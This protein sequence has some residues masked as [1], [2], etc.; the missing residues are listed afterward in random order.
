M[1][2]KLDYKQMAADIVGLVGGPVFDHAVKDFNLNAGAAIDENP[3]GIKVK[4][5]LTLK[6]A[7]AAVLAYV[8][9]S[10]TP[11]IPGL[12]A[13]GMLKV[14]LLLI[15][16]ATGNTFGDTSTYTILSGVADAPFFFMPILAA[17]GAATKLGGTTIYAM[18]AAASL[19]HGN[20]T[21]LVAA[22]EPVTLLGIPLR[23]M[24]YSSS[25]LPALL[26][27][28]YAY[29]LE[30]FFNKIVPGIFKSLLVGLG[31]VT[32]TGI[33]GFT[34]L[35]PLGNFIGQYLAY[36]FVFLGDKVGFITVAL[37]AALLPWLVMAGMHLPLVPF[38][39]QALVDPGYDS[40]FRP[41]FLLHNMAEG[42]ACIGVAML[43]KD[44]EKKSESLGIAFGCIVTGVTEPAIYGVSLPRRKPMIGVMAGVMAG[45]CVASLLG[46]RS[47]VMGYSTIMA[48]PIFQD[49]IAAAAIGM[50]SLIEKFIFQYPI[51]KYIPY[52]LDCCCRKYH[53]YFEDHSICRSA[54]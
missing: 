38:M 50:E 14:A 44:P 17:Y 11:M 13:G 40:L 24:T 43:Q 37:V 7:G 5:K 41:A 20:W 12:V 30:K 53:L 21:G 8:S 2:Q 9:G 32:V 48:L 18:I 54:C 1:A 22:G 31:T 16:L 42:G 26:L 29:H 47:Y 52:W 4:E 19:L 46:T 45:G 51:R 33:L 39:T 23:L 28:L 34:I 10:M 27:T 49:T 15:N 25:L 35:A 3:D 36:V 6:T